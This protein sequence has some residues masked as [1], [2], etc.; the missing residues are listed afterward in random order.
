MTTRIYSWLVCAALMMGLLAMPMSTAFGQDDE[1]GGDRPKKKKKDKGGAKGGGQAGKIAAMMQACCDLSD[2]QKEQ[3][4]TAIAEADEAAKQWMDENGDAMKDAKDKAKQA[5]QDKDKEAAQEAAEELAKLQ[6][7]LNEAMYAP[8]LNVLDDEQKG[9][10]AAYQCAELLIASMKKAELTDEQKQQ[11]HEL[12]AEESGSL[13]PVDMAAN[14]EVMKGLKEKIVADVLDDDQK[15]KA[16]GGKKGG[17]K[18]NQDDSGE[19]E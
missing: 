6:A 9:K 10:F 14:A 13:D 11:I 4:K 1:D 8:L 17:G 19:E 3:L 12:C 18:K 7:E 2:E 15:A 16:G 5:K